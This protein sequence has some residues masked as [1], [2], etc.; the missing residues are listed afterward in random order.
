MRNAVALVAAVW[1]IAGATALAHHSLASQFDE[2]KA[3]TLKGVV[4]KVEWYNPH[5]Y[6]YLD[7]TDDAGKVRTW[8][9]ESFPPTTLRRGGLTK[10]R[11]GFGQTV[12]V[13]A[14]HARNGSDLA[15]LRKITF[16]D[17]KEIVVWLGDINEAK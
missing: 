12:T 13:L 3:I 16:A 1:L 15:F 2:E 9:V 5:V 14:Y 6:L 7:V 10:D 8:A 11:L 17:G 4:S